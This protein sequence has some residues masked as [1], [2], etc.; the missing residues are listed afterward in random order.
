MKR[1]TKIAVVMALVLGLASVSALAAET[2]RVDTK[3]VIE[4]FGYNSST[5]TVTFYGHVR[6][7]GKCE[8]DRKI[9]LKQTT[10][11]IKAGTGQTNS[12]GDWKVKFKGADVPGGDFQAKAAESTIVKRRHGQVVKKTICKEGTSKTFSVGN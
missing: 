8:A 1:T 12:D 9:T 5:D 11:G 2:T 10:D 6:A 7:D 3:V 4:D